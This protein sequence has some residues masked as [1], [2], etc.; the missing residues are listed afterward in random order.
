VNYLLSLP[1]LKD[2]VQREIANISRQELGYVLRST[3]RMCKTYLEAS[4]QRL[5]TL[6]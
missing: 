2:S 6:L 1:E 4:G 3:V 5:E